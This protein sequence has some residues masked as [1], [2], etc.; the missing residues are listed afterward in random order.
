MRRRLV[1]AETFGFVWRPRGVCEGVRVGVE[2]LGFVCL[3]ECVVGE[4][5][6]GYLIFSLTLVFGCVCGSE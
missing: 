1:Y 6:D 3:G 2:T 5:T 4:G